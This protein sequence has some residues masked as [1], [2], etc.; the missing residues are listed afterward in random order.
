MPGPGQAENL[1]AAPEIQFLHTTKYN[2]WRLC[3]KILPKTK[4]QFLETQYNTIPPNIRIQCLQTMKY[5]SFKHK[6][7]GNSEWKAEVKFPQTLKYNFCKLCDKNCDK[8]IAPSEAAPQIF[9]HS[10][11]PSYTAAA[12]WGQ[13]YFQYISDICF[14]HKNNFQY[15][16]CVSNMFSIIFQKSS[17][18]PIY[19]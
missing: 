4:I 13:K 5:N 1:V 11:L 16:S 7:N 2:F 19:F 6:K 9:R 14:R 15:I 8:L 12:G 18:F 17:Q 10:T 3:N